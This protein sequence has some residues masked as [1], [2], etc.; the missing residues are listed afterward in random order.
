MKIITRIF[1]LALLAFLMSACAPSQK[2]TG[3]WLNKEAMPR[4]PYK[5]IYIMAIT[6]N[7][8]AKLTVENKLADLIHSHGHKVIVSSDLFPPSFSASGQLTREQLSA[9]LANVGCDAVFI[10]ALLDV[11]TVESYQPGS[12]YAPMGYGYYGSYYGY[13]NY[14]YPVVYSPG[15]YSTDK[16]Y[17]V[18]TNFYDLKD[19]LLLWSIQSQAYNPSNLDSF[20]NNY[21][22][23]LLNKLR[24][25]ELIK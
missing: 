8:T 21:S 2:V 20:F 18:E 22:K 5:T 13:Y 7:Q 19:D 24:Q 6:Q 14:Y 17:Y 11:K 23:M 1:S 15:Y 25:E 3:Y 4:G 9:S 12:T 10:A 16:T